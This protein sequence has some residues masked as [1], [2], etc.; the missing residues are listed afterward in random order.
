MLTQQQLELIN[1]KDIIL[2][3]RK[4]IKEISLLLTDLNYQLIQL[5]QQFQVNERILQKHGKISSGENYR[6][7]PYLV[8]D[9]PRIFN[10]ENVFA[11]RSMFWWGHYFSF[12]FHASGNFISDININKL[13][14]DIKGKNFFWCI[15][16]SPFH[17]YFEKD[18]YI[19]IEEANTY[20]NENRNFIKISRM[21]QLS[22]INSIIDYG[23][24]TYRI[25]LDAL[26]PA[27]EN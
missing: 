9:Y 3:K 24:E 7:F 26:F 5:L 12:T 1:N 6:L 14:N 25:I 2:Q 15:H 10:K 21:L 19:P 17:Y 13:E 27:I 20:I 22:E 18:N 8:L 16:P 23:I 11:F 4:A